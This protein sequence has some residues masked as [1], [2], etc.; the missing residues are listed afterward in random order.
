MM[1]PGLSA[2]DETHPWVVIFCH[3]CFCS[4]MG[5]ANV[6]EPAEAVQR[7]K[8]LCRVAPGK[9]TPRQRRKNKLNIPLSLFLIAGVSR[10]KKPQP[11]QNP[12]PKKPKHKQKKTSEEFTVGQELSFAVVAL[13]GFSNAAFGAGAAAGAFWGN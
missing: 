3:Y 7:L 11:K 12:K 5:A 13:A 8:H 2:A 4:V 6:P 1:Q 9:E 10:K